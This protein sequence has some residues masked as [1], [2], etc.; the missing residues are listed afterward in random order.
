MFEVV[1]P[2]LIFLHSEMAVNCLQKYVRDGPTDSY[3]FASVMAVNCLQ[4][5]FAV[6]PPILIFLHS[7]MAVNCLLG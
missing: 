7:E 3:F 6:V 1:P 2:I 4:C 5:S